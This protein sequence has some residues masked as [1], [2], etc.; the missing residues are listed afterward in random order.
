MEQ[1]LDNKDHTELE[2]KIE[3]EDDEIPDNLDRYDKSK[4]KKFLPDRRA[5]WR[6]LKSLALRT[7]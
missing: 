7:S 3:Q 2:V 1:E 6:L 4:Y 5:T